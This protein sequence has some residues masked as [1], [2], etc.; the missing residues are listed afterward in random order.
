MYILKIKAEKVSSSS[1]RK[2]RIGEMNEHADNCMSK[3]P[4]PPKEKY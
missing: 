2:R 1:Q 4:F 3:M